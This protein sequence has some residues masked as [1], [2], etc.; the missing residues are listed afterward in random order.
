M[1]YLDGLKTPKNILTEWEQEDNKKSNI[2][3]KTKFSIIDNE[4]LGLRPGQFL[5]VG[6]RPGTGKT[7]FLINLINNIEQTLSENEYILFISFEQSSNEIVEKLFA[8]NTCEKLKTFYEIDKKEILNR[9]PEATQKLKEQKILIYDNASLMVEQIT[10][11]IN[12]IESNLNIKIKALF[13]DHI[14]ITQ[15]TINGNRYEKTSIVSRT[16]KITALQNNIPVI[17]LS[18]LSRDYAKKT[19]AKPTAPNIT[20]L[21]DSGNLEQDADIIMFLYELD[22]EN[23]NLLK[24]LGVSI[25]KNRNGR[26]TKSKVIF[27]PIFAKI[28]DYEEAA[29]LGITNSLKGAQNE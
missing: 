26:L 19:A 9:N 7:T 1:N 10:T 6:G 3:K 5:I 11:L 20:D 2:I 21:R 18:Q 29:K 14:Q 16:L 12:E 15:T 22:N 27:S 28:W 8:L 23:D 13:L 25:V 24:E 4:L 17:A